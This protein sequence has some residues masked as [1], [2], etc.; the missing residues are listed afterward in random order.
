MAGPD[1]MCIGAQKA[2]TTW[3]EEKLR[4]HPRVWRPFA[5]E[6]HY[7]DAVGDASSTRYW[8]RKHGER[9]QLR[10]ERLTAA[11]GDKR[12]IAHLRRLAEPEFLLTTEWYEAVFARKPWRKIA[13]DFTPRYAAMPEERIDRLLAEAPKARFIYLIRDPV[14]R[15]LSNFRMYA[16]RF[17]AAAGPDAPF[18]PALRNW[19]AAR[20]YAQSD[21]ADYIPRWDA[22][23][24]EGER[25]LY[26]PYGEVREDP[27]GLLRR[28]EEFLGLKPFAG[29]P[30]PDE[31]VHGSAKFEP[32]D[33]LIA[34][35]EEDLAPH[36]DF[37]NARFS[38]EFVALTK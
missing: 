4:R 30:A 23:L 29:Y 10:I 32:P 3:L 36:R 33:W 5:K 24:K 35:L 6:L 22:R 1:F 28:V 13:G 17:R 18:E 14:A 12:E 26:L 21:Y 25:L 16:T 37:L 38:P 27:S 20:K 31:P 19:A 15:A 7:F 11:G 2:A 8:R 9:L 34:R